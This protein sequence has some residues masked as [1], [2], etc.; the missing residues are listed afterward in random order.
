MD[1]DLQGKSRSD[2][3][4][5]GELIKNGCDKVM[6]EYL[7]DNKENKKSGRVIIKS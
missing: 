7:D 3:I 6:K 5:V 2:L 1:A 4:K